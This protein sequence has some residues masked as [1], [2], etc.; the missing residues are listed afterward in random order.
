MKKHFTL[1]AIAL[2]LGCKKD[3]KE[4]IEINNTTTT[5]MNTTAPNTGTPSTILKSW[6]VENVS[7]NEQ[8]LKES[9]LY[10]CVIESAVFTFKASGY[11][12]TTSNCENPGVIRDSSYIITNDSIFMN[13]RHGYIQQLTNS[14]L[15]LDL[16]DSLYV[17]MNEEIVSTKPITYRY[18]FSAQ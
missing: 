6:K 16:I 7:Y 18:V 10:K 15:T 1:I 9:E 5:P 11:Y 12:E 17:T 3:D 8:S 13:E 4:T 14:T 2:L